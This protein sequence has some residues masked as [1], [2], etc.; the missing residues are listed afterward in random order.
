MKKKKSE[1]KKSF[2]F[3]M[4]SYKYLKQKKDVDGDCRL[5]KDTKS[6]ELETKSKK[7]VDTLPKQKT[8]KKNNLKAQTPTPRDQIDEKNV[9]ESKKIKE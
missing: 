6:K 3:K 1:E 8:M 4:D 9:Y 5:T 7:K 2:M